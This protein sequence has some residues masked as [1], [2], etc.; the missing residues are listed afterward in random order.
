M[1][2]DNIYLKKPMEGKSS[3]LLQNIER[4]I[5]YTQSWACCAEERKSASPQVFFVAPQRKLRLSKFNIVIKD[6]GSNP[7][8]LIIPSTKKL[9]IK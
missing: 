1:E 6:L 9:L 8:E 7:V 3:R 4:G 5:A 2:S